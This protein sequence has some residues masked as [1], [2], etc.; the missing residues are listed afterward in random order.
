[1]EIRRA[2]ADDR[3]A[4][5]ELLSRVWE[6]DYI[7]YCW[8]EWVSDVENG[9]PLVALHQGQIAG[10]AHIQ[11]LDQRV[12]WHQALRIDPDARRLGIGSA[13]ARACLEQTKRHGRQ[14]ARLLVDAENLPSLRLTERSGF[15]RVKHYLKLYKSP[16]GESGP[17]LLQP[18][19]NLLPEL[20][21]RAVAQGENYWHSRWETRDLTLAALKWSLDGGCLRVLADDPAAALADV[22]QDEDDFEMGQLVGDEENVV[23]LVQGLEREAA[24]QGLGQICILQTLESPHLCLLIERLGYRL[25]ADEG[26]VIWEYQ[27]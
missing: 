27:L 25:Q 24:R 2:T 18:S 8:D 3:Q 14:V 4:V 17:E 10:V 13:L 15:R 11:F 23:R 19:K 6:D 12:S 20:L 26:Y 16:P 1:M 21:Q 22:N 5:M 7:P 9:V